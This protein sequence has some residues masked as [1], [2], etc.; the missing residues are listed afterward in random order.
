MFLAADVAYVQIS[1]QSIT[2]SRGCHLP[3]NIRLSVRLDNE[4]LP[5]KLTRNDD[6]DSNAPLFVFREVGDE[7]TIV[8]ELL[9][10]NQVRYNRFFSL[11]FFL[12]PSSAYYY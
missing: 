2:E 6:V 12:L 11:S 3:R 7:K 5:L 9:I 4:T 8:K 10:D 1:E